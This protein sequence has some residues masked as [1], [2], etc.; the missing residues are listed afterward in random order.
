MQELLPTTLP[1]LQ[2]VHFLVDR[3]KH[4]VK[5]IAYYETKAAATALDK[6]SAQIANQ[7]IVARMAKLVTGQGDRNLYEIAAVWVQA[8]SS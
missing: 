5:S 4:E 8:D 1:G 7:E 3:E 6:A 2:H